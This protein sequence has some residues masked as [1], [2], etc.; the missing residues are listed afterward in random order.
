MHWLQNTHVRRYHRHYHGSGHVWQGRFKSFPVQ[1][2]EHLLTVLRY[3]ER[4]PVRAGLVGRSAEWRWSSAGHWSPE[5][6]RP[7]WLD[8]GPV[9][10]PA[11]WSDWVDQ[12][13]TPDETAQV[14]TSLKR[15]R[16]FGG[17]GWVT[18]TA[19]RLGLAASLRPIG[20]PRKAAAKK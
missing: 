19:A 4:N 1:G 14:E 17:D 3:V 16:P 12:P 13:L 10:R 11:D 5:G 7:H 2:D 18:A 6:P 15:G 8:P 20:R 9:A